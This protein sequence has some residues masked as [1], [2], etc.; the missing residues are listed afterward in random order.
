V[1]LGKMSKPYLPQRYLLDQFF[2]FDGGAYD[3]SEEEFT[4]QE[5]MAYR[6][7]VYNGLVKKAADAHGNIRILRYEDLCNDPIGTMKDVF[8]WVDLPW[9][10]NC[11][12]FISDALLADGDAKDYH[13][14]KRNPLVAAEKWK[15]EMPAEDQA[16]VK[17][18]ARQ[19]PAAHLFPDLA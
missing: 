8:D 10:R 9:H 16:L 13:S 1:G 12:E 5:L 19:S 17:S 18:I 14:F 7:A 11:E 3:I 6:W 4:I 15:T 2:S